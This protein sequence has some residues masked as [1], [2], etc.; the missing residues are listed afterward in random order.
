MKAYEMECCPHCGDTEGYYHKLQIVGTQHHAF[1]NQPNIDYFDDSTH[2]NQ[3][4]HGACRC[5]CCH[6][7]ISRANQG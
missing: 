2:K 4:T 1:K 5:L 3:C 7:I 6:K